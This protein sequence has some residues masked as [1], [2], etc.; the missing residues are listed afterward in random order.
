MTVAFNSFDRSPL[1]A[2]I[3]SPQGAR[4]GAPVVEVAVMPGVVG[5]VWIDEAEET[6]FPEEGLVLWRRDWD[7]YRRN[8]LAW[9]ALPDDIV[10]AKGVIM[11]VQ[12]A[13]Q[14]WTP[15]GQVPSSNFL[16]NLAGRPPLFDDNRTAL[17]RGLLTS[18]SDAS[19]GRM[20]LVTHIYLQV[21]NS[22]SMGTADIQPGFREFT[23]WLNN[24]R[25]QV[26]HQNIMLAEDANIAIGEPSD[27]RWLRWIL[28]PPQ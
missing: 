22:G 19:L 3:R 13:A 11:H 7:T 24:M 21:G 12:R 23:S 10:V 16:Y 20:T 15:I 6:Y 18:L 17:I 4:N 25:G 28:P 1:G 8:V 26:L 14:S 9:R 2:F 27:E 5:M